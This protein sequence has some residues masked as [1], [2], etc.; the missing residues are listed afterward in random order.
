MAEWLEAEYPLK[1]HVAIATRRVGLLYDG[2]WLIRHSGN[3]FERKITNFNELRNLLRNGE[4]STHETI[5]RR[6][7]FDPVTKLAMMS[8]CWS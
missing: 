2:L 3:F 8:L 5:L 6:D 4:S 1:R 7:D